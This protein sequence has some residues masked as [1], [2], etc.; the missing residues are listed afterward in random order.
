V[1]DTFHEEDLCKEIE[2]EE[3]REIYVKLSV[4]PVTRRD[5]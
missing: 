2:E 4:T 1:E 3:D 5:I